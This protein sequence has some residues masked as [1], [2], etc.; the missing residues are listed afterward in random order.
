MTMQIEPLKVDFSISLPN[1]P[2]DKRFVYCYLILSGRVTLIDTGVKG[3][4]SRNLPA[5]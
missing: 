5:A 2:I 1:G 4:H 3:A